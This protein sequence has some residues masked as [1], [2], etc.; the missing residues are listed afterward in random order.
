MCMRYGVCTYDIK[1]RLRGHSWDSCRAWLSHVVIMDILTRETYEYDDLSSALYGA[2]GAKFDYIYVYDGNEFFGYVDYYATK[3]DLPIYEDLKDD[4]GRRKRVNVE[5]WAFRDGYGA[6][7]NRKLWL[8]A[9]G[10][11]TRAAVDRHL[12][13]HAVTFMNF[14]TMVGKGGLYDNATGLGIDCKNKSDIFILCDL[15]TRFNDLFIEMTGRP[16]LGLQRPIAWTM[17]GAARSHYLRLKYA[18]CKMSPLKRYQSDFPF[19]RE[20]EFA[21]REGKLLSAGLLYIKERKK[22]YT[23]KIFKYDVNSLFPFV[24]RSLPALGRL[25]RSSL[26]EYTDRRNDKYEYILVL[27]HAEF[28]AKAGMPRLFYS[29]FENYSAGQKHVEINQEWYIFAPYFEEIQEYYEICDVEIDR[30]LKC[31]K[32]SDPAAKRY[33]DR[34]YAIKQRARENNN[35]ALAQIAK[36]F[37]NNLHGKF[38]QKSVC[39]KEILRYV[40]QGD[41]VERREGE[42]IDEWDEKHFDFV[43]GAYIYTMARVHIMRLIRQFTKVIPLGDTLYNHIFYDD[44]DS[45]ITDLIAPAELIDPVELGKLKVE[46]E[47]TAFSVISPKSYWGRLVNNKISLVVAGIDKKYLAQQFCARWGVT[48]LEQ[49]SDNEIQELMTDTKTLYETKQLARVSGGHLYKPFYRTL[50]AVEGAVGDFHITL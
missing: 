5:C 22:L 29:P 19:S 15:L 25:E 35:E 36:F 10:G 12:R 18:D 1:Y 11:T 46:A 44:T 28:I 38:A 49:Y 30:V 20:A 13:I 39:Y 4:S 31:R 47:F 40:R 33:I 50:S 16:F 34:A 42:L 7:Y 45:I 3:R 43:R 48:S 32:L 26:E 6:L 2:S 24:T 21:M 8:K 27:K 17:G 37:L 23:G 41:I 14:R 9:R